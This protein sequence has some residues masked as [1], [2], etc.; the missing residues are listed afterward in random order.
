MNMRAVF[1]V[2][3]A[4]AILSVPASA[5]YAV[6]P[7][8]SFASGAITAPLS[9][10]TSGTGTS[11]SS[12]TL[13]ASSATA[14]SIVVPSF[15]LANGQGGAIG[16]KLNLSVNA[17]SGWGSAS[18]QINF[19]TAAPTYTNGDGGTYAA[20]AGSAV[21]LDSYSCT[22]TQYNDTA[23]AICVP[24][25]GTV[26]IFKAVTGANIYW[27]LQATSTVTKASGAVF[28]LTQFILN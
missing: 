2:A 12:G 1:L 21:L 11:L 8:T 15:L 13:I 23:Q 17:S 10:L 22:F 20:T 6:N 14:G 25:Q 18:V 24:S 3:L 27:D 16:P 28:T 9:K 4:A 19:W 26:S 5:Q 7:T